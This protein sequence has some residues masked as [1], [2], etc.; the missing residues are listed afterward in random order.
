MEQLENVSWCIVYQIK[1][2][3]K[4]WV[5]LRTK[6]HGNQWNCY[7]LTTVIYCL[8]GNPNL[9]FLRSGES[10][11]WDFKSERLL[12]ERG[13]NM[14]VPSLLLIRS[15]I[16]VM[17]FNVIYYLELQSAITSLL[18]ISCFIKQS[19]LCSIMFEQP[20]QLLLVQDDLVSKKFL[21]C[22]ILNRKWHQIS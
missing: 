7:W 9:K 14:S 11:L 22:I 6:G 2:I 12:G 3:I 5:I 20:I 17:V 1:L 8:V 4:R 10:P 19:R 21:H 15:I 18:I 16:P 13:R